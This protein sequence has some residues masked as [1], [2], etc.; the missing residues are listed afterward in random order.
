MSG[1]SNTKGTQAER[2]PNHRECEIAAYPTPYPRSE[3]QLNNGCSPASTRDI[4]SAE[5][6]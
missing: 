1:M 6:L 4:Y 2:R 3:D 5:K